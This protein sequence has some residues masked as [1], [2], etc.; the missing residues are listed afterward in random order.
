MVQA[1]TILILLTVA[2]IVFSLSGRR[3]RALGWQ[4]R[5]PVEKLDLKDRLEHAFD[6]L[7][8][9]RP[10]SPMDV[11]RTRR[12]LIQ[13]GYRDAHHLTIYTG[14]RLVCAFLGLLAAIATSGLQSPILLVGMTGVGFFLPNFALKR[15]IQ[16]RQHRIKLAL[17]DAL[18]LTVI[19]VEAGLALD[20]A[21]MRVGEDLHHAH[22]ELSD[23]LYLVNR[24]MHAGYSW[25]EALSDLSQRTDIGEIKILA[26]ALV[27][28]G[29]L[30]VVRVLRTY[31]DD[32]R[33]ARQQRARTQVIKS[34]IK[35]V[36]ALLLFVIPS[37]LIVTLGPSF[38]QF[39]RTVKPV[40]H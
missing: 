26:R 5:G 3:L 36:F 31:S 18:D 30:G 24:G 13:A 2:L 28:A 11:S 35:W 25:D 8:K 22:P 6:S 16:G 37:V 29:P 20:K 12:W 4:R 15:K 9:A 1:L 17:P 40:G 23:E 32:L 10:S 33:L 21:M 38:I 39:I 34:A 19:C 14:T 27:R 7:S